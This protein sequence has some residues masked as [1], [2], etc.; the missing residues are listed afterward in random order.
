[1]VEDP[2]GTSPGATSWEI[3]KI[4]FLLKIVTFI[5]KNSQAEKLESPNRATSAGNG[6][7]ECIKRCK[8]WSRTPR[9]RETGPVGRSS[10]NR[11]FVTKNSTKILKIERGVLKI[12]TPIFERIGPPQAQLAAPIAS[13]NLN[14]KTFFQEGLLVAAGASVMRKDPTVASAMPQ[15]GRGSVSNLPRCHQFGDMKNQIFAKNSNI[16]Y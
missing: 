7:Q 9:K 12:E 8:T 6:P 13:R 16:C 3:R 1:M 14:L 10:K 15:N 2:S 11:N 4:K 5:A